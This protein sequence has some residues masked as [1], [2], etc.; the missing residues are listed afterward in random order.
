MLNKGHILRVQSAVIKHVHQANNL[1]IEPSLMTN[2][3][4]ACKE[5]SKYF[6][7]LLYLRHEEVPETD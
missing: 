1:S 4:F 2:L 7:R 3:G 5:T 6:I